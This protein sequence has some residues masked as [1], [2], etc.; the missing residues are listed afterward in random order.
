M[1]GFIMISR[2]KALVCIWQK[3]VDTAGGN[4][5]VESKPSKGSKFMIHLKAEPQ[6]VP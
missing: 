5:I 3:I 4:I 6:L 2:V 1:A